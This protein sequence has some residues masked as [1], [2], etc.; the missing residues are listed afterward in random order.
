MLDSTASAPVILEI[1]EILKI[2]TFCILYRGICRLFHIDSL[3][4][5]LGILQILSAWFDDIGRH[6]NLLQYR[7]TTT[8]TILQESSEIQGI[9]GNAGNGA[10]M[11]GLHDS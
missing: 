6:S 3:P 2:I 9:P 11:E 4:W 10:K 1:L 7:S 5:I 8:E